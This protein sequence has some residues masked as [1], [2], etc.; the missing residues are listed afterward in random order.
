MKIP[1]NTKWFE[2]YN[3]NPKNRKT[4]DCVFRSISSA[5]KMP[6][7]DV[8]MEMAELSCKNGYCIN[9]KKQVDIYLKSKGWTK[10]KQ[11]RKNDNTKYIG[12][13]FVEIFNGECLANIGGNHI[14]Y[15]TN[16][17]IIDIFDCSDSCIGNYYI[18]K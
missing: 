1:N 13:E 4:S 15:I 12:K 6:Y 7:N 16:N 9:D 2:Y 8:I 14:T 18:M 11:P 3:A 10:V 5:L 17:K